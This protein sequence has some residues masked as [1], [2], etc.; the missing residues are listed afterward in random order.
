[1]GVA[2]AGGGLFDC[3]SFMDR[4][5]N[6]RSFDPSG[7]LRTGR[8]RMS[9]PH[10][11]GAVEEALE[12]EGGEVFGAALLKLVTAGEGEEGFASL[13]DGGEEGAELGELGGAAAVLE[14][15]EVAGWGA[16]RPYGNAD[17]WGG[18]G[19]LRRC[20]GQAWGTSSPRVA[21]RGERSKGEGAGR[22]EGRS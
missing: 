3:A 12:E 11:E 15:V 5:L 4:G 8:L 6:V 13:G 10:L 14:G 18:T 22:E 16:G 7:K 21:V 17:G 19:S 20:S 9:G 1:M 2:G